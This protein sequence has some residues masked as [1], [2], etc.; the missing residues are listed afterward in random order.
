MILLSSV[1]RKTITPQMF[2]FVALIILLGTCPSLGNPTLWNPK[3]IIIWKN[4]LTPGP[5]YD[6]LTCLATWGDYVF[7]GGDHNLTTTDTEFIIY[8]LRK[9]NGELI[10]TWKLNP[11]SKMDRLYD[12]L[13]I[14]NYLYAVG[15]S[16]TGSLG[17]YEL[18]FFKL[19]PTDLSKYV[20]KNI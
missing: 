16:P 11:T 6:F 2:L 13:V 3:P 1:Q 12:C 20:K 17:T 9:S 4:T 15:A 19:D 10:Q 8:K 5:N 14:G 18:V 7:V